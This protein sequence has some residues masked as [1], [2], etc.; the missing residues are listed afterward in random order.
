M[1][2]GPLFTVAAL[3]NVAVGLPL[4]V[5]YPTLASLLGIADPPS[6]WTHIV[7]GVV[8]LFGWFYWQ[9][10]RDPVRYR[11]YIVA[12]ILGKLWFVVVIYGHWFAGTTP[13]TLAL[14]VTCD[15]VFAILFW[16]YLA[17]NR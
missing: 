10:A 16:R 9:V 6:V 17:T 13:V 2:A 12:G 4:L 8:L 15:L 11:P 3:F 7:A 1:K 14:L 5:A